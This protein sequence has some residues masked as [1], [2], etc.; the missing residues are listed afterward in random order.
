MQNS[1]STRGQNRDILNPLTDPS[2]AF[3]RQWIFWSAGDFK[4]EVL[5]FC[6]CALLCCLGPKSRHL[7]EPLFLGRIKKKDDDALFQI[8]HFLSPCTVCK[9]AIKYRTAVLRHNK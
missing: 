6:S 9:L 5:V 1:K 8:V 2:C 3:W 4:F 7:W